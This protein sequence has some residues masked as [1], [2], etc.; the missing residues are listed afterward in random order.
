MTDVFISYKREERGRCV[1]IYNAL[2]DLKLSVWFDAHI[3]PGT[4]FD[5]EIEREVRSAKAVLVLWSALAAD[6]DWIR[7]EARTGRQNERLV[8]ARL[9]DCL[10]PLEF[11]SVQAV[12]LFD[13]RDFQTG[14][15]WR[16]V[17]GRI[18]RLV[19]R[20]GLGDYVRCEQAA[21][22]G[23]WRG[24]IAANPDD[25]LV[26][27]ARQRAAALAH[28]APPDPGRAAPADP[29]A[30]EATRGGPARYWPL[31]AGSALLLVAVA[32]L[33][34]GRDDPEPPQQAPVSATASSDLPVLPAP[35][36]VV[37][38]AA[39]GGG[40]PIF[41]RPDDPFVLSFVARRTDMPPVGNLTISNTWLAWRECRGSVRVEGHVESGGGTLADSQRM[42][43]IVANE[44][45]AR[46]VDPK[47]IRARGVGTSRPL[48]GTP[49]EAIANRR[50]EIYL[51]PS[52]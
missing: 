44:L 1:A 24:W 48:A 2:V 20:P 35:A 26:E 25:P 7:A 28:R 22:A 38:M 32:A 10:P 21:D 11:A 4:D 36:E 34:F 37:P 39:A 30:A 29:M 31:F 5:R 23:L 43:D 13:R 15:G 17:V 16:Q 46:G 12:D 8:A 19:G 18:G 33:T 9:D 3:E 40:K 45:R 27:T 50:V 51:D 47:A 41:C 49:V 52:R 14:E 6:S 42:A